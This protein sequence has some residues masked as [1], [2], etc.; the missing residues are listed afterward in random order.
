MEW[1]VNR[2]NNLVLVPDFR[3][4]NYEEIRRHLEKVNWES[5]GLGGDSQGNC[6]ERAYNNLVKAIGEGQ[7]LH[8]P[9]RSLSKDNSD[10]KWMTRGLRH[11][12]G[13]KRKLYKRIKNGENHLRARYNDLVRA[14][15]RNT[16]GKKKL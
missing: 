4:A 11:E 16:G 5:L 8:I 1:E 12:I 7:Q 13:L 14:V 10:P 9:Y 2:D 3:R 15:K 6:V